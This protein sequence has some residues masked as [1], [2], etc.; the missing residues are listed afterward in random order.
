MNQQEQ[1]VQ[2]ALDAFARLTQLTDPLESQFKANAE[3]RKGIAAVI[4][5]AD[6]SYL[7]GTAP[8]DHDELAGAF[9]DATDL[10][11][12]LLAGR[13]TITVTSKKTGG[14]FTF[15]LSRPDEEPG[16]PR[17]RPIWISVLS[18]PDNTSDYAYL[19]TIWIDAQGSWA[20][21]HGVKSR[22]AET[23]PSVR[24]AR[25]FLAI[26]QRDP[27]RLFVEA[28]VW[29]A[30]RCGRCGRK[31]TVPESIATGFGPECA[32]KVGL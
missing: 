25:W 11:R 12:F 7:D 31:L 5:G 4:A 6:P 26:L 10:H 22:V 30:G 17:E 23:A 19:G 21:R 18:G 2:R 15:K 27:V 9:Q 24:A 29:H 13:A 28:E 20:Y 16:N 8:A 14:R 3:K 1:N 32:G